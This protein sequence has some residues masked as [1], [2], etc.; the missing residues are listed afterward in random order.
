MALLVGLVIGFIMCIPVGPINVWVVNTLLKH[1]FKSAFSI[2]L[3]GSLM[4]FVYFIFITSGLSFVHF[5][6]KTILILKCAGVLFLLIFG[7]KE[8]FSKEKLKEEPNDAEKKI[9]RKSSFFIIGVLI[10]TSNP[11]LIATMTGLAAFI[12]SW[13][14]FNETMLNH[15]LLAF[16]VAVGSASWFY[17]LLKMINKH[18]KKIPEAFYRH[19]ARTSGVLII[20]FSF[21]MAFNV[22]K[23]ISL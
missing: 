9:P 10:Y 22:Y 20:L 21:Y 5:N 17:L 16:G 6:S 12:K 4:D 7:L 1:N 13:H 3:G 15:F 14:L 19:F 11:T 2:A 23:E 8:L 18:Q